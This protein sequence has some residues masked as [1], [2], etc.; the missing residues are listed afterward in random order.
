MNML[1]WVFRDR[2]ML[3]SII[4]VLLSL[5]LMCTQFGPTYMTDIS[6]ADPETEVELLCFM[7]NYLS[8]AN[9]WVV[10]LVDMSGNNL[11]GFI[12]SDISL[13]PGEVLCYAQGTL[14]QD[15]QML[16]IANIEVVHQW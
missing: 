6:S 9:G 7:D 16:F 3:L 2:Y 15:G 14:S 11:H 1:P 10:D 5:I 4:T 13:P 8:S 12:P